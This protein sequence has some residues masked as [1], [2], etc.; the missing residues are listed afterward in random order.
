MGAMAWLPSLRISPLVCMLREIS[1]ARKV[2]FEVDHRY[3]DVPRWVLVDLHHK[4]CMMIANYTP[5]ER[6]CMSD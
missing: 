6:S 3:V 2:T 5:N 1:W 4:A